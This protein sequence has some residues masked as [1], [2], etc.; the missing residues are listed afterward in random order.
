MLYKKILILSFIFML[1]GCSDFN[2]KSLALAEIKSRNLTYDLAGLI[3]STNNLDSDGAFIFKDAGFFDEIS[4]SDYKQLVIHAGNK[5]NYGLVTTLLKLDKN[6]SFESEVLQNSMDKAVKKGFARTVLLL[7]NNG[8]KLKPGSL[9][10]AIYKDDY[11]FVKLIV[12][13]GPKYSLAEY[14]EALYVAGRIGHIEAIRAIVD[15]G[16]APKETIERAMFGGAITEEIDVVKYLVAQGIDINYRSKDKCTALHYLAQDGTVEMIKYMLDS[17]A[18][19]NA[20]CRNKET[21][22]KW[23]HYGKNEPVI[24][25]LKKNGAVLY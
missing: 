21:P 16:K 15:S 8:A 13:N 12:A 14:K 25:Y 1:S 3:K 17:G 11:N 4:D 23:A 19:I 9:F 18:K 6:V 20:T 5:N 24:Q 22:L 10:K 2:D 7:L